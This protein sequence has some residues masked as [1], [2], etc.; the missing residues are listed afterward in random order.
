MFLFPGSCLNTTK[1]WND[2]LQGLKQYKSYSSVQFSSVQAERSFLRQAFPGHGSRL[3]PNKLSSSQSLLAFTL[4]Y[5]P[6][7]FFGCALCTIGLVPTT[8]QERGCTWAYAQGQLT[9]ASYITGSVCMSSR[10]SV[11]YNQIY[12]CVEY[13]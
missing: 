4:L 12:I 11:C 7:P 3:A 13:L 10:D 9:T 8:S 6:S 5:F 2:R 1:I